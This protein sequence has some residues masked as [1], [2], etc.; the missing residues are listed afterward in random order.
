MHTDECAKKFGLCIFL[1]N[2]GLKKV[3]LILFFRRKH[4]QKK[5][6]SRCF[7]NTTSSQTPTSALMEDYGKCISLFISINDSA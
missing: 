4:T 6:F 7:Y 2:K 5:N 3:S 1:T